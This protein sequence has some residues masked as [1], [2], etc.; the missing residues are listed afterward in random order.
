MGDL[1]DDFRA[2]KKHNDE[3]KAKNLAAACSDGWVVH[4]D[5]H[6]S[7]VLDGKRIDYWPSRKKF[8]YDGRVMC[9]DVN[10]FIRKREN[11]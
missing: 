3:R 11:T 9:G 1:A 8:Q 2:L 5:H 10:G 6:W 7:R 4:T